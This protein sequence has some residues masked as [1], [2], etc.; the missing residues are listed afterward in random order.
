MFLKFYIFIHTFCY[1]HISLKTPI[2]YNMWDTHIVTSECVQ[3]EKGSFNDWDFFI[4]IFFFWH[5]KY[6]SVVLMK[7]CHLDGIEV[8]KLLAIN[9]KDFLEIIV[10]LTKLFLNFPHNVIER[11]HFHIVLRVVRWLYYF[12]SIYWI[13]LYKEKNFT[14]Q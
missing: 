5:W 3:D 12:S 14:H 7:S 10:I 13:F 8:Q 6:T 2:N 1:I 11:E 4:F 9:S